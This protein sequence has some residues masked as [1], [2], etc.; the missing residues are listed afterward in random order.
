MPK[1]A[2]QVVEQI[3]VALRDTL[4]ANTLAISA[5]SVIINAWTPDDGLL[6]LVDS[7]Q[8][9]FTAAFISALEQDK[10]A[11]ATRR[12]T[13]PITPPAAQPAVTHDE[14]LKQ[15]GRF[16]FVAAALP[17]QQFDDLVA[18][19]NSLTDDDKQQFYVLVAQA[20]DDAK[21][22]TLVS[23]TPAAIEAL[24]NSSPKPVVAQQSQTVTLTF[25]AFRQ[26][27]AN[28]H[29]LTGRINDFLS[30]TKLD[31]VRF[32]KATESSFGHLFSSKDEFDLFMQRTDEEIL[33]KLGFG[34]EM[35][36]KKFFQD[37]LRLAQENWK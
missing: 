17:Q 3:P 33:S 15:F 19:H 14:S 29:I 9:D 31:P 23:K 27:V 36:A 25:N 12:L 8:R 22:A 30:R 7:I 10:A 6:G 13:T 34:L 16:V 20:N 5:A 4:D 2:K 32:W 24:I 37:G 28:D 35:F 11:R 1:L 21:L 26:Q 18:W